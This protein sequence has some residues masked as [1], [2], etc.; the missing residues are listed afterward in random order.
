MLPLNSKI[1]K[2][3]IWYIMNLLENSNAYVNSSHISKDILQ[4]TVNLVDRTRSNIP[5][6]EG[7]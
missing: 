1:E 4:L 2:K 3:N 5:Q 7:F 6:M